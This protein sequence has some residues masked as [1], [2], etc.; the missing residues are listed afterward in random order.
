MWN[1]HRSKT[2]SK[3]QD[4]IPASRPNLSG[5][6][7]L[8]L[9]DLIAEYGDIF[10]TKSDYYGRTYRVYRRIHTGEARPIRQP[11]KRLLLA[12]QAKV[13]TMLDDMQRRGVIEE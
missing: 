7:S 13:G 6:E 5:A 3:L 4:V 9:E 10:T 12:K 2:T 8:E 11:P 1:N